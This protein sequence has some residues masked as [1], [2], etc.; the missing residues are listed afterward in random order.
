MPSVKANW[1][2]AVAARQDR[3]PRSRRGQLAAAA[4][5]GAVAF[6][7]LGDGA[8]A[9]TYSWGGP[10]STTSTTTYN[11]GTNWSNPPAGA[12]PVNAGQTAVFGGGGSA[13]V[14]V[15]AGPITPDSWI[16]TAGAYTVS[17]QAVNFNGVGPNL[18]NQGGTNSISNDM[19]GA[20]IVVSGGSLTVSGTNAFTS[21]SITAGALANA[22]S[23][24]STTFS[25]SG[26]TFTN[27]GGGQVVGTITNTG[28]T[29]INNNGAILADVVNSSGTFT[30]NAGGIAGAISNAGTG[31]NAGTIA[32]LSN[33]G[34]S[35]SNTDTVTNASS[36]SA[37]SVS[38]NG[39]FQGTL[40]LTGGSFD[41]F[42]GGQVQGTTTNN[43]GTVTNHNGAILAAVVNTTG[44]FDNNLGGVTGAVSNAGTGT[45]AGIIASLSNS[46][47]SFGNSGTVI[48]ASTV[49]GGTVTNTGTFQ[50]TLAVSGGS[51]SNGV[52]GQVQGTTT[53]TGGTVNANGGSFAVVVNGTQ[54]VVTGGAG[55]AT[56]FQNTATGTL[57]VTS[58]DFT[59]TGTLT[60]A[61]TV[62]VAATRSLTAA[63][64]S[65]LAGALLTNSG[66]INDALTNAGTV[67]N[68]AGAS[69]NADAVNS[70]TGIIVNDGTWNGQL[71]NSGTVSNAGLWTTTGAGFV[72]A[73]G[74]IANLLPGSTINGVGALSN[75]GTINVMGS[76]TITLTS[77]INNG[78]INLGAAGTSTLN[79]TNATLSGNGTVSTG[80]NLTTGTAN[81]I[82]VL[83]ATGNVNVVYAVT[84]SPH[85][86]LIPIIV[87][88]SG[89]ATNTATGLSGSSG[90][91]RYQVVGPGSPLSH[92]GI[93]GLY[94]SPQAA[95]AAAPLTSIL[96]AI[97]AIDAS[98]HQPG[99]NLMGSPQ[100]G[101]PCL[102]TGSAQADR[103]CQMAGGPWVRASSGVT[104][105]SST[106]TISSNGAVFDQ[107]ASRQRV[108]FSGVQAGAD[109]GWLNPGGNGVNAHAGI[110]GGQISAQADEQLS[111]A[112]QVR[113]EVP[114]VGVY[115]VVTKGALSTDITYRHSWYDMRVTNP[116]AQLNGAALKGQSDNVNASL[117]Y[118]IG[119]PAHLFIEPT[120]GLSY[121]RSTFDQLAVPIGGS[122]LGIDP[123]TSLLGRAGAR[124]GTTITS[125]G[126]DWSPFGLALVQ[127]EFATKATGTLTAAGATP[128]DV[129]TDRIGTFYQT[130]LGLSFQSRSTGLL[131]FVRGDY[132][133]GAN[134]HGG[135]VVAGLRYTFGP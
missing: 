17:G 39:T 48:G 105:I 12:P 72:N 114:F 55:G 42:G 60:N 21:T 64:I 87:P 4:S 122:V 85:T 94:V 14:A 24:T 98:F 50:S 1:A 95:P 18:I 108:Q 47:G 30:N 113:F 32:S 84:G 73:A 107:S 29:V 51:F 43:G 96:S 93:T 92:D 129:T 3:G 34:G 135:A 117:S 5:I 101:T 26:G 2:R 71:G 65:N 102:P 79:A 36:V 88:T 75:A 58:G 133:T 116:V 74:G 132:R 90:F 37:G 86:G 76:S 28:G 46:A 100:T 111:T 118:T 49:S 41:N 134:L 77:L 27:N 128:F 54:F 104:S 10:G 67:T 131:G 9:Q 97:G 125:G 23:L 8:L 123:L 106:A 7:G 44:S 103:G 33:S 78:T 66:T 80:V 119:L 52:G 112:S 56:T 99:A 61:G 35:F 109:S 69:Y 70:T 83:T 40:S 63:A 126:V 91:Y 115:A 15:T 130:S 59:L 13:T 89:A 16:F 62:T 20:A 31:S 110:T 45:N 68:N 124:V 120:A 38:N 22:G 57:G 53:I 121:T 81:Q 6:L 19:T 127:H 25:I 11:L 82:N